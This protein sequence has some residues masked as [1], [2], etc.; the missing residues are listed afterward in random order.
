[1]RRE[2]GAI[3]FGWAV[4]P[5]LPMFTGMF[6]PSHSNPGFF[7]DIRDFTTANLVSPSFKDVLT[8]AKDAAMVGNPDN[9]VTYLR[10]LETHFDTEKRTISFIVNQKKISDVITNIPA[11]LNLVPVICLGYQSDFFTIEDTVTNL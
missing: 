4:A 11:G 5:V 9:E 3:I 1:M 7:L 6:Y 8:P 10:H 2:R